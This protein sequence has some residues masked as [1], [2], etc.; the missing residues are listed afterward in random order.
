M[1]ERRPNQAAWVPAL[2]LEKV[3]DHE[4]ERERE[5]KRAEGRETSKAYRSIWS[6]VEEVRQLELYRGKLAFKRTGITHPARLY[7]RQTDE[8]DPSFDA[9][10]Q[11]LWDIGSL[12]E[13]LADT[14]LRRPYH[15][16]AKGK[17]P[18]TEADAIAL[19]QMTDAQL[20]VLLPWLA[21]RLSV[22]E[23][24]DRLFQ[25]ELAPPI[26]VEE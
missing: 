26:I 7:G 8:A 4:P 13:G 21:H 24:L 5:Q 23:A 14:E 1:E 9:A 12:P 25:G 16:I 3:I 22:A 11:R 10:M 2:L 19:G 6:R 17:A 15:L 18:V 20:R